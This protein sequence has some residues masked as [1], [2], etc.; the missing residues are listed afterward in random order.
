MYIGDIHID[1]YSGKANVTKR[2]KVSKR[3]INIGFIGKEENI[4]LFNEIYLY[5]IL[6]HEDQK[7]KAFHRLEDG[8]ILF[9]QQDHEK[10][11]VYTVSIEEYLD[12][13][14]EESILDNFFQGDPQREIT[15]TRDYAQKR[16][17]PKN[18]MPLYLSLAGGFVLVAISTGVYYS[19]IGTEVKQPVSI[20]QQ[21]ATPPLQRAEVMELKNKLSFEL[22]EFIEKKVRD[23]SSDPK[24]NAR[25]V[26]QSLV[27]DYQ[28]TGDTVTL[29]GSLGYEYKYPVQGSTLTAENIYTKVESFEITKNKD[30]LLKIENGE[31]SLSCINR[32]MLLTSGDPV[33]VERT[34]DI[35]K[36]KYSGMTPTDLVSNFKNIIEECPIDIET[37]GLGNNRFE[38]IVTLFDRGSVK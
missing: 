7:T 21:Q 11:E 34:P 26:I 31:L 9:I 10:E 17:D 24:L 15:E 18:K 12:E 22:I 1:D 29:R 14:G 23:I 30:D 33:V 16:Y 8:K 19:N 32:A 38:V 3:V 27:A 28:T 37:I 36:I 2:A 25:A 35:L 20:P 6:C 4:P 13:V 5:V